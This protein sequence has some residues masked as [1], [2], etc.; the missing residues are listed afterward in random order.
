VPAYHRAVKT[1]VLHVLLITLALGS[2]SVLGQEAR[3]PDPRQQRQ[4]KE[5]ER[6]RM[7]DDMREVYRDRQQRPERPRQMSPQERDKLRRD[8]EETNRDLRRK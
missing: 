5:E 7:R 1:A 6:Q 4:M 8:I 3:K 2:G